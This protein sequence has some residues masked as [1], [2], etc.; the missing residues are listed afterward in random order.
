VRWLA[1]LAPLL[2]LAA[3]GVVLFG[4]NAR[5]DTWEAP[6]FIAPLYA[7]AALC[8]LGTLA[9]RR[10]GGAPLRWLRAL[11]WVVVALALLWVW[12]PWL[13]APVGWWIRQVATWRFR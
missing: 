11:L 13:R 9:A 12:T 6:A 1:I 5:F 7:A 4:L 8:V 10:A 3:L 2:A